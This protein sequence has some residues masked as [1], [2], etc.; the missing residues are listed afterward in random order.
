MADHCISVFNVRQFLERIKYLQPWP[1]EVFV[2]ARH[3]RQIVA[4]GRRRNIAVL[5]RHRQGGLF[6]QKPL[7]RPNM[8]CGHI[9]AEDS[10]LA[11]FIFGPKPGPWPG[12]GLPVAARSRLATA[13]S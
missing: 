10:P 8:R 5:N 6:E 9:E 1:P 7:V 13:I 4:A 2:T 3:N 12:Y 11:N